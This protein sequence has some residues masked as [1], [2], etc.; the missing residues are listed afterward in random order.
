MSRKELAEEIVDFCIKYKV[1]IT[2]GKS[3]LEISMIK[4]RV[5]EHLKYSDFV[6]DLIRTL[7]VKT[8]FNRKINNRR[9][10]I[11]LLKLE[12][13]R[14]DLEYDEPDKREKVLKIKSGYPIT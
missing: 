14:L 3:P 9:L 12:K 4:L 2:S 11:L 5:E 10:K 13:I 7:L 6:E 8:K 1:I